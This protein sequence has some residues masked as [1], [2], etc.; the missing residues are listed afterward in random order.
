MHGQLDRFFY[1][2]R[3]AVIGASREPRKIGYEILRSLIRSGF[4]GRIY[5][6]NPK[7]SEVLGLKCYRSI[8]ETLDNVDLAVFAIPARPC[9]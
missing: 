1:A 2:D 8:L 9:G 4:K 7:C 5:P 3:V 6:V